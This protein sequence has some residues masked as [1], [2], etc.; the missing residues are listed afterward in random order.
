MN[1]T[2]GHHMNDDNELGEV[3]ESLIAEGSGLAGVHMD[4]PAEAVMARGQALRLR[5]RL[6]RGLSGVT[7]AGAAMALALTLPGG[8]A[9]GFRQVHVNGTDWSVNTGRHGAVVVMVK[10]VPDP[11]RLQSVLIEA[12]VRAEV[13][14]GENCLTPAAS[15]P[16][17]ALVTP[18]YRPFPVR[19][20]GVTSGWRTFTLHPALQPP[21]T[22]FVVGGWFY[23]KGL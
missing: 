12:G 8:A 9:A 3:R 14:W 13:R 19:Q 10:A 2:G 7:A 23:Y 6:L 15:L 21:H 17:K 5:R 20:K 18:T 22:H 16:S 11:T 4:R 1:V